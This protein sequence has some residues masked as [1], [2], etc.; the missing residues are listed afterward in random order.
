MAAQII[1]WQNFAYFK[2]TIKLSGVV[3]TMR[4]RWNTVRS[5]WTIDLF[6]KNGEA[7]LLGQKLVFNTDIFARYEDIRLPPG[8]LF[9]IDTGN[10]SQKLNA[11]GRNDIGTNVLLIY[12]E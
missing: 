4:A 12:E 8:Q 2:Q 6:D 11:I 10:E 9:C 3:Y 7:I 1:P 5:F